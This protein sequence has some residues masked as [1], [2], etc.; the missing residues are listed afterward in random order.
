MNKIRSILKYIWWV[1]NPFN[2]ASFLDRRMPPGG[3]RRIKYDKE[4]TE[5]LYKEKVENYYK[6]TNKET[7]DFWKGID[8][9]LFK[10]QEKHFLKLEKLKEKIEKD[11]EYEMWYYKNKPTD[12]E[13]EKQ[14][15][16]FFFKKPL[17]SIIVPLYNTDVDFFRE[18]LYSVHCQTYKNWELCLADGSEEKRSEIDE[19]VKKD[20]RIKYKFIGENKGISGNSNEAIKLATGKYIA[21]LDHDDMLTVN[22]LYEVVKC[23]NKNNAD[24]IYSDEDKFHFLDE[25]MFEPFFKPDYAP[26]TLRSNNYI[27]HLCVIKKDLLD[28]VGYF[29]SKFDGAQDF[30]LILRSSE[31]A[32]KII[33]I[34]KI[35]YH[36]RV[37]SGSTSMNSEVKPYAIE[38]GKRAIQEELERLGKNGTVENGC[39]PGAYNVN[40]KYEDC[41]IPVL[42]NSAENFDE[43]NIKMLLSNTSYKSYKLIVFGNEK[44]KNLTDEK[45]ELIN[46]NDTNKARIFNHYILANKSKYVVVLSSNCK[47]HTNDW[48]EKML[49]VIEND[50]VGVVG[51]R[52]FDKDGN[53]QNS[54]IMIN[55]ENGFRYIND[56]LKK[57]KDGYFSREKI[58][59]N[60]SAVSFDLA[61]IDKEIYSKLGGF[62]EQFDKLFG[63]DFCMKVNKSKNLIIYNPNIEVYKNNET[64]SDEEI[65]KFKDKWKDKLHDKYYNINFSTKN[66][67]YEINW[68]G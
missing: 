18:L 39:Y 21:L 24:F 46:T 48:I 63:L 26:D 12:Q 2:G 64:V 28:K 31:K 33:H 30:D 43:E 7:A 34:P 9:R 68:N 67:N 22:A 8:H 19:M 38:A 55:E 61:M 51:T 41:F 10:K 37:H 23:I 62:D 1:I 66:G 49:G 27:C 60:L 16:K 35:L 4:H 20:S 53:T 54:G 11:L 29:N 47:I 25:E 6:C 50:N 44:L 14:S 57:S 59:Q 40:Y 45:I 5:K 17:I 13:L 36:W 56:G 32:K 15:K 52:F 42:I 58:V 65:S 3:K